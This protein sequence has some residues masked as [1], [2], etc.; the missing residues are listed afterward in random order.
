MLFRALEASPLRHSG[1]VAAVDPARHTLILEE[2]GPWTPPHAGVVRRS[3]EAG[4]G[5]KFEL[6]T[7]TVAS[8]AG[9]WPGGFR[10]STLKPS[11]VR[12]GDYATV[13]IEREGRPLKASRS[14][15]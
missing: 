9:G 13:T 10:E 11:D 7:R 12:P 8:G 14:K 4:S 15:S 5:T 1:R 2:T 3:I 6:A